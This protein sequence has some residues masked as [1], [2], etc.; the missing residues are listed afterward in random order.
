MKCPLLEQTFNSSLD[1]DRWDYIDCLK[2][3]CAKWD[4]VRLCCG[5]RSLRLEVARLVERLDRQ[6]NRE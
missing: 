2:E 4:E 1:K 3:E 6:L 5:D